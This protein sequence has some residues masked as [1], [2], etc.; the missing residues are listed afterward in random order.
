MENLKKSKDVALELIE[1]TKDLFEGIFLDMSPVAYGGARGKEKNESPNSDNTP[2]DSK[3]V[4]RSEYVKYDKIT[5]DTTAL[6]HH[7][8]QKRDNPSKSCE[9]MVK[10]K[11]KSDLN[12]SLDKIEV[13][14]NNDERCETDNYMNNN[15]NNEAKAALLINPTQFT[16][17]KLV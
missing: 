16:E 2:T 3:N 8:P 13:D 17:E 7:Y 6:M 4:R 5:V 1:D 14:N 15:R 9:N 10:V 11:K 12:L